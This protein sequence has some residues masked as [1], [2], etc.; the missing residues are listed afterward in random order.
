MQA[1][2]IKIS[3]GRLIDPANNV[4]KVLDL[5]LAEGKVQALGNE[6]VGFNPARTVDARGLIIIP[7]L[8]DLSARLREPGHEHKATIKSETAAAA[9]GGITTICC[10]PDTNPVIDT[11]AVADLIA[12]TAMEIGN[13]R[14]LPVGA[15]QSLQGW[16]D[17]R[18]RCALACRLC[19]RSTSDD[20]VGY[21]RNR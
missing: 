3:G 6:P 15:L 8:V 12:R 9:K 18:G 4:D 1:N 5:Y 19:E 13:A 2:T 21:G 17:N 11:P 7:G 14:V 10:P 20:K 16:R